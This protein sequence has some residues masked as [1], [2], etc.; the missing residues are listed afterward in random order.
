MNGNREE[1]AIA[2]E[3]QGA[4]A[5]GGELL[6]GIMGGGGVKGRREEEGGERYEYEKN[7]I[8][9]GLPT[10]SRGPDKGVNRVS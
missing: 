7:L 6:Q 4:D 2:G 8:N 9:L 3:S 10:V 1:A 5:I